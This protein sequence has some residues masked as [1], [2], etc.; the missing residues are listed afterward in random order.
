MVSPELKS[1]FSSG[2]VWGMANSSLCG[3][4][5]DR[6]PQPA[7]TRGTEYD[8]TPVDS[9]R[10]KQIVGNH[11]FLSHYPQT[12]PPAMSRT[13]PSLPPLPLP[14]PPSSSSP[15]RTA[16]DGVLDFLDP[17]DLQ[18]VAAVS[19]QLNQATTPRL[20]R[21]RHSETSLTSEESPRAARPFSLVSLA[22]YPSPRRSSSASAQSSP[23]RSRSSPTKAEPLRSVQEDMEPAAKTHDWA[24]GPELFPWE[25]PVVRANRSFDLV[26]DHTYDE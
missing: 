24:P 18:N 6:R 22:S 26:P 5:S 3:A 23:T 14:S 25:S 11:T 19:R 7:L 2:V 4:P 12:S 21:R 17:E 9:T 16:L 1:D 20:G 10:T 15:G 8:I 13:P